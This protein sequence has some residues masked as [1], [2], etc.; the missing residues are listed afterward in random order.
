MEKIHNDGV[1][2]RL[3]SIS[4]SVKIIAGEELENSGDETGGVLECL[5]SI[6]E[7]LK[8]IARKEQENLAGDDESIKTK[9]RKAGN[10]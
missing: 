1:L 3:Q 8:V 7:S 2:N 9:S 5:R 10:K 4:N 6:D